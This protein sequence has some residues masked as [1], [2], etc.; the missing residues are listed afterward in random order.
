ME[1]LW[2]VLG[3]A[4]V[5]LLFLLST[6]SNFTEGIP[7]IIHQTAPA[8]ESKWPKLWKLCQKTW[9][10][11]FP[12]WEYRFW[13]DDDLENLIKNDYPWFYNT[14]MG[15]DQQIKRVDAARCFI[16]HK[17]GGMY[18][19]MDYECVK[20]FEHLL[21]A[22]KVSIAESPFRD[23][24]RADKEIHQN[25]LMVSPKGHPFWEKTWDILEEKK[26]EQNVVYATG[27]YVIK[28]S[29]IEM[30]Y[31]VNTLKNELFAPGHTETF[32]RAKHEQYEELPPV[33]NEKVYARHLG[34]GVWV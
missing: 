8:D 13:N 12:D 1:R 15:Y 4:L 14:Y 5:V 25:A 9:W 3:V 31:H 30:P 7:R 34:T 18:A 17:Y 27:P 22:D 6:R 28:Q 2:I 11:K 26:N 21:P 10:E 19:D 32:K 29:V 16:L 24:G 33:D 23:D 20:N